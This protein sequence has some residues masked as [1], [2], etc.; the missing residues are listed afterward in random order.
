MRAAWGLC[1]CAAACLAACGGGSSPP[2]PTITT[3]PQSVTV[4]D[5]EQATLS[6]VATSS[7]EAN[8]Q[9]Q[10]NGTNV[11]AALGPS[12]VTPQ[13]IYGTTYNYDVVVSNSGGSVTSQVVTVTVTPVQP[14]I[15]T[16]PVSVSVASGSSATFSVYAGGSL[17]L[18]YQWLRNGT[19]IA[20]ATSYSLVLS[21][22]ALSDSGASFSVQVTN[23]A[24]TVTSQS[25]QLTVTP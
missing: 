1:A 4:S 5:R 22:V 7:G 13:L 15:V 23:P 3:Q 11:P 12:Y 14:S 8:Y 18:S 24:G 20:G 21:S 25:A 10:L 2:P 9:W 16:P 17:P 6:V 19:A